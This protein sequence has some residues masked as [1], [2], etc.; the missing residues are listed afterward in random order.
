LP[1]SYRQF[2]FLTNQTTGA[3]IESDKY[4]AVFFTNGQVYFGKLQPLNNDYMKLTEHF[5]FASE[6]RYD[7]S[8]K[9]DRSKHDRSRTDKLGNE[10]HGPEDTMII[11]KS[12]VLFF[13]NLKNDSKVSSTIIKYEKK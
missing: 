9:N 4:Q 11:S 3:S 5:L 2:G 8:T 6:N 13:E 7:K 1:L 10:I 12:Q